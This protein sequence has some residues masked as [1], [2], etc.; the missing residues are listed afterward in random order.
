MSSGFEFQ[1]G[2][3]EFAELRQQ[4]EWLTSGSLDTSEAA[5]NVATRIVV[6]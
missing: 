4:A 2:N 6:T 5:G 3:G 1:S